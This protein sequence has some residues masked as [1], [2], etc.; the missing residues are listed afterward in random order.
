MNDRFA[1]QEKRISWLQKVIGMPGKMKRRMEPASSLARHF[2]FSQKPCCP[3][4]NGNIF[5]DPLKRNRTGKLCTRKDRERKKHWPWYPGSNTI[6]PRKPRVR[7]NHG[8]LLKIGDH[9][10][11][12]RFSFWDPQNGWDFSLLPNRDSKAQGWGK[13]GANLNMGRYRL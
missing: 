7:S 10:G 5:I 3:H 9:F 13:A 4:R 2:P 6:L 8:F 11:W 12:E 1:C